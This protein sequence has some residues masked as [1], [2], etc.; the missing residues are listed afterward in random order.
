MASIIEELAAKTRAGGSGAL[1]YAATAERKSSI[2]LEL[3]ARSGINTNA[4]INAY[5][6]AATLPATG[7]DTAAETEQKQNAGGFFGG[8]G[9]LANKAGVGFVSS[10]E[11]GIDYIA[12]GLAKLFGADDWAEEVMGTDW[13]D[14][15]HPENWYNPSRGW[16]VAGDVFG[17]IGTSLPAMGAVAAAA[18]IAGASGGTL[19]P[20]ASGLIAAGA[21]GLNAAGRSTSEA[22]KRTGTLGGK[23]WAYGTLSGITE[24]G[25]EGL[26]TA[27]G[28][29][30][31]RLGTKLVGNA[32]GNAAKELVKTATFGGVLKEMGKS[33]IGEASEE[34]ISEIVDPWWQ[35]MTIDEYA[36]GATAK[37]VGYAALVGGLSGILMDGTSS[38]IQH[39]KSILRGNRINGKGN[40][41]SVLDT[42]RSISDFEG[43]NKTGIQDFAYIS[44]A[45]SKLTDSIKSTDGKVTTMAQKK[46]LGDLAAANNSY[47][48]KRFVATDAYNIV[49]NAEAIAE[50]L[51]KFGY[52]T[53]D[54]K[55]MRYSA[56]ELTAGYDA[57][58]PKSI[59][60]ALETNEAL[61]SLAVSAATGRL[62]IDTAR[63]EQATLA[64]EAL[65]SKADLARFLETASD[66][67]IRGVEEAFGIED[68]RTADA[69]TLRNR[70][71]AFAE[72]G[73]IEAEMQKRRNATEL[74]A[75]PAPEAGAIPTDIYMK[76]GEAHRYSD[77]DLNIAISRKGDAYLIYDYNTKKL[78]RELSEY[79]AN[80]YLSEYRR[81]KEAYIAEQRAYTERQAEKAKR[82][83]L[84]RE[85][86]GKADAALRENIKGYATSSA[87]LQAQLR[88]AYHD[89]V[90]S[91]ISEADALSYARVSE[92]TGL[93]MIFS[94]RLC[95]L[96]DG[97][98]ADGYY[99]PIKNRIV[100][101]PETKRAHGALLMHE[102]THAIYYKD[103]MLTIAEGIEKMPA[104]KKQ[105]IMKKYTKAGITDS[106]TLA[107][108]MNAHYAEETL[109]NFGTLEKL[110]ADK[111]TLKEKILSFFR[112]A[113]TD[114]RG[115]AKLTK[116]AK[117]LYAQYKKLFDSFAKKGRGSNAMDMMPVRRTAHEDTK[118][119]LA[120]L[121]ES[122]KLE[123]YDNELSK[124][125][126]AKGDAT[127]YNTKEISD[128]VREAFS[129]KSEK[130]TAYFGIISENDIRAIE[131][132]IKSMPKDMNGV[133]FKKENGYSLACSMDN[134]R[135]L[136]DGKKLSAEDIIDY[137]NRMPEAIVN[138]DSAMYD[139]YYSKGNKSDG[140]IFKKAFSDGT[141]V[142]CQVISNKNNRL[143]M[144]T[145]YMDSGSYQQKKKSATPLLSQNVQADTSKTGGSQTS[146]N[147]IYENSEK[148]NALKEKNDGKR[149]SIQDGKVIVD[150]DQHIFDG[151]SREDY[152]KV[153][154]Q[155]MR[156][157]FRGKEIRGAEFTK[158]SEHEYTY[159]GYTQSIYGERD[160]VYEAKMKAA[161]E[162]DKM[163]SVGTFIGHEN[164]K[165]RHEYN[166]GGYDRYGVKF[167]LGGEDFSG[168]TL[169]AIG[170]GNKQI[171]YDIVNI[172]R[173]DRTFTE[174][175]SA[176]MT[177]ASDNSIHENSEKVNTLKEKN[178]GKRYALPEAESAYSYDTLTGKKDIAVT[179]LPLHAPTTDDGKINR[180]AVILA[181][182]LNARAQNNAKNTPKEIFVHV[183]DI[184]TDV[185][186]GRDGLEHGLTRGDENTALATMK[187]GDLL[188]NSIAV[189][190]LNGRTKGT[191]TSEMSYVLLS[192]GQNKNSPYLVRMIV[193]KNTNMVSDL[194][195]Y[196]LYAVKAKKEGALFMP[197]GNERV[198]GNASVSYLRSDI[199]IA[200]LF[201][202]VKGLPI[203][204]EIFSQD[205]LLRLGAERANGTLSG[206]VRY[207]L[208]EG[209]E[210]K[211]EYN[212]PITAQDVRELQS[213]GKKSIN[214]FT[215]EELEKSQKWAYK[216]YRDL[217]TK[218]PFFRAWFGDWRAYDTANTKVVSVPT[219]DISQ[220]TLEKGD[221]FIK[222][223][224]WTV[225]AGKT[226]ND[227]TRH[228]SGGNRINVKSLNAINAILDNAILLDT[229]VSKAN[230][231]KKSANTAF[232]H[233]LYTPII[234]DGKSYIAVTTVEEYYN[235][236]SSSV[237]R[238]A[239]NLKAIKIEPAGGQLGN[240]SSSSVPVTD[241][242]ISISE[243][244]SFVKRYDKDFSAGMAVNKSLVNEDGTPLI[245]YHGT[246]ED[247]T[248][249]DSSK[250]RSTMDI[251]GMFFSPWEEDASGYG[252]KVGAYYLNLHNPAGE[253]TAY[254]ALNRFA[255][256]NNA[257]AKA[258]D[259]LIKLGYD[260][261]NNGGE[262]YIAFYPHQIKSVTDNIG[263][264][265]RGNPDIRYALPEGELTHMRSMHVGVAETG[266]SA[267]D[268]E[269]AEAKGLP[270]SMGQVKRTRANNRFERV[271]SKKAAIN[272]A[273]KISGVEFLSKK[274]QA[275]VVSD[276]W[277][278][279]NNCT[280]MDEKLDAAHTAADSIVTKLLTEAK[281]A[282]PAAPEAQ[283]R[284]VQLRTGLRRVSFS[285]ADAA[286]IIA[287]EGKEGW[288]SIRSRW[289]YQSRNDG[290]G[291]NRIPMNVFVTD[292]S[293]EMPGMERLENMHPADAFIEMNRI[294][295]QAQQDAKNKRTQQY[296]DADADEIQYMTDSIRDT[297]MK[298]FAEEGE[299]STFAKAMEERLEKAK[300]TIAELRADNATIKKRMQIAGLLAGDGQ[301][302]KDIK[303]GTF[304]NATQ[305]HSENL[306]GI[307][308]MAARINYR[309]GFNATG[310]RKV[311]QGL[312]NWY[313]D[314]DVQKFILGYKG[315]TETGLYSADVAGMLEELSN[316]RHGDA[317][318]ND[319]LSNLHKV[320]Q[321]FIHITE[322]YGKIYR[323][324][325]MAEA[326]PIAEEKIAIIENNRQIKKN[327]FTW[328]LTNVYG[329]AI[330]KP[331][332]VV[333]AI[334]GYENG[335]NTEMVL[336]IREAS[337]QAAIKEMR[338]KREYDDFFAKNKKYDETLQ[339]ERMTYAGITMPKSRLIALYMT[340]KREHA[341]AGLLYSGYKFRDTDGSYISSLP[342]LTQ[343]A[344]KTKAEI[345]SMAES[346]AK[347]IES[348]FSATDK[349][350][351]AILERAFEAAGKLKM[352][353]DMQRMGYSNLTGGYYFP[354]IRANS[355]KSIDSA[356]AELDRV[357]NA[358]FN[359]DT[360]KGAKQ[361]LFI[362]DADAIFRR[363][364]HAVSQYNALSPVIEAYN[365]LYNLDISGN[366]NAPKSIAT[367]MENV[368]ESGNRYM[369]KLFSDV[370]GIRGEMDVGNKAV[371][372]LRS[373]YAKYQLGFNPKTWFK[374]LTSLAASTSILDWDSLSA[375]V[376]TGV[377]KD[378]DTY[379]PLAALRNY[380]DTAARAQSVLDTAGKR[381]KNKLGR[382]SDALMAPIG[383]I[384][385]FVVER[386]FGACQVQVAKESGGKLAIG[387][388][389]NKV[390]AGKML[391][392]V[393][394]DTQQNALA[395]EKSAAM[396]SNNEIVRAFTM[397]TAD[398][399]AVMSKMLGT[400][401]EYWT[402]KEKL[403]TATDANVRAELTARL[404]TVGKAAR[405]STMALIST[406][407]FGAGADFLFRWLY[408][409]L[410][411]KPEDEVKNFAGNTMMGMI[412]GLPIIK[413]IV[414]KAFEGYDIKNYTYSAMNDMIS[415][416]TELVGTTKDW[417]SDKDNEQARN[418]ALKNFAYSMGQVFGMPVRNV[419]N[420]VYG[421]TK[422][423]V[424]S[425][426]YEWDTHFYTKTYG[427]DFSAA[428]EKDD[429][430]T[431][432]FILSLMTKNEVGGELDE[433]ARSEFTAL[434]K[435]G[436]KVLPKSVP[437]S[438]TA[439]GTAYKFTRSEKE[440]I[441]EE[442]A[443]V[444]ATVKKLVSNVRYRVMDE[445]TRAYALKYVYSAHLEKAYSE[446][447]YG[448][449]RD[450]DMIAADI[451]GIDMMAIAKAI[452]KSVTG[453]TDSDGNTVSGSKRQNIIA[454]IR[455]LP[456]TSE[457]K[458]FLIAMLGYKIQAGDI[459]GMDESRAKKKLLSYIFAQKLTAD[460]KA[461]LCT[462]C[463]FEVQNGRVSA[464]N[465]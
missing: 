262:E 228:H 396:R 224:G 15:S 148:V 248:V 188:K 275:Q 343:D 372:F 9:Y 439:D 422:R 36:P 278:T 399:V 351:I 407:I 104:E 315:T 83:E 118:Y 266:E 349:Q 402:L 209:A 354:I 303:I 203:A 446:V 161:T 189:N 425:A 5:R 444:N 313:N 437:D 390:E 175:L 152:G 321:H 58:K 200:D 255:G 340:C 247:F 201:E 281:E 90:V 35:R 16:Q 240:N 75:I 172:K 246:D 218:S 2:I 251:Q 306:K 339:N 138:C 290:R 61:R 207:A 453:D 211:K 79:E 96:A 106:V 375:G 54:G 342:L 436:N 333:R 400:Y 102:L 440:A 131:K 367:E 94:R 187:I 162:L 305:F 319:E 377:S 356:E 443:S 149:Y 263:T 125:I 121:H 123:K 451:I 288:K 113:E 144:Q 139:A 24:G 235:E 236:T 317:F 151:V 359:K 133:L 308:G 68:L 369:K 93:D 141:I 254:K 370:Q 202:N 89:A 13:F 428:L 380:E 114:Y 320:Y 350:Y 28:L 109:R 214:E 147:R 361:R 171:F 116:A 452:K 181:G 449:A 332:E 40:T 234:Y 244:Y 193:D 115:D 145:L 379:C 311:A 268:A 53:V 180:K 50:N 270:R 87:T 274:A 462:K 383:K 291:G 352:E 95:S 387:T 34:A 73:G 327:P 347:E 296:L 269:T 220:A 37:E 159:S 137:L 82:A 431:A 18:A 178:D 60:K 294:Y 126:H 435:S 346:I 295:E 420:F 42:A 168:E 154:R 67:E 177:I 302:L 196:G 45:Y 461:A 386:L 112:G 421:L 119:A 392:Q 371:N 19:T 334:D 233:K 44:E 293:R 100:I 47:N 424:P 117:Q 434:A 182:R 267:F 158:R 170:E 438:I 373:G 259:Y 1:P 283:Q 105:A 385:R 48:I 85:A 101:N 237:S 416:L 92:R 341:Q 362:D 238:R 409:K 344:Q 216:F 12:G 59:Y 222:D 419:Y 6:N 128:F 213:I 192:V 184:N 33:F 307:L 323:R 353:R 69:D 164:A 103:G 81:G 51:G 417:L 406:A 122:G 363:H 459:G 430:D 129:Q 71:T 14:Y 289:G 99:D 282:N 191:R 410:E 455:A 429:T 64:G 8:V 252:S 326:L 157:H 217:G 241:S 179:D 366:P 225:Y 408:N 284:L 223:T 65:M 427:R 256:Q 204:S 23:E 98:Y 232:L 91:G 111:P 183:S 107:D 249:F 318:T 84:S 447:L 226:L 411:D 72:N 405:K 445:S 328:A 7:A 432:S 364:I 135:R 345:K 338:L 41:A 324:G 239:Y 398:G 280:S 322:N 186:V 199:S 460:E 76:D 17:G 279:L 357:S 243:L 378:A 304:G 310:A 227:D 190:E 156:Q 426:A 365:T 287:A 38:G 142:T 88:K 403:K 43:K 388:E 309:G 457:E 456:M 57:K 210:T 273:G 335:F 404:K 10:L 298:A 110:C 376:F 272:I 195:T 391:A 30:A 27:L 292:I 325:R 165:H 77:G 26:S 393:I 29:G 277:E 221:Y 205:V 253:G 120:D 463:G 442:Y 450:A 348:K 358:S 265:D 39:T 415:S 413:D 130:K 314:S 49:S 22:Y 155:Y 374:Q 454:R 215:S 360:V 368:W 219:I 230:T 169:V 140:V 80:E 134:I 423:I 174:E 176:P 418:K 412:G 300:N 206:D 414:S 97:S 258:R 185:R 143:R 4:D 261:V 198:E 74:A 194:S 231:N 21:A 86:R 301:R 299:K 55:E 160:G 31:A 260:G 62:L 70:I 250:G 271:Y 394:R 163:I 20:I 264:F 167:N 78:S 331:I 276:I 389:A 153:V 448:G 150:T 257:G 127:V 336:D 66:E 384:D 433:K 11:G 173:G 132:K 465:L 297:I 397:F 245:V 464:K 286:E 355:A 197:K 330:F 401:G 25:V 229:V 395:T 208:P 441:R 108:E 312:R 52:R 166:K 56:A 212:K 316:P 124:I 285:E 329:Q 46:L 63:T 146:V 381:A 136:K 3:A 242:I 337:E 32:G 382:F 458:L